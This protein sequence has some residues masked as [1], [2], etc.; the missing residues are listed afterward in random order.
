MEETSGTLEEGAETSGSGLSE[1]ALR[2]K[3]LAF[4]NRRAYG[5]G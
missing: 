5:V 1:T 4:H 2:S 3:Y